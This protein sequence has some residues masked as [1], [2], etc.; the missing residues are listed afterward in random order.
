MEENGDRARIIMGG[1]EGLVN[2]GE[3]AGRTQ[4]RTGTTWG[5]GREE[6]GKSWGNTE[7]ITN[8]FGSRWWK[9]REYGKR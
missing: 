8:L 1:G 2:I 6:M 7:S 9:T 4:R 3:S 5:K